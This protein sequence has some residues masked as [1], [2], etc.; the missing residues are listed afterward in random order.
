MK[1]MSSLNS[2]GDNANRSP[3]DNDDIFKEFD[4]NKNFDKFY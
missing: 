2:S 3:T 1:R 4:C